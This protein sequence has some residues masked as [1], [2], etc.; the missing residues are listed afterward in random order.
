MNWVGISNENEFYSE[1]YLSEVFS[2]DIKSLLD[3]WL[4]QEKS[5]KAEATGGKVAEYTRTP[6]NRLGSLNSEWLLLAREL[7]KA[8]NVEDRLELQRSWLQ[9]LCAC[10]ELPWNAENRALDDNCSIPL[11]AELLDADGKPVLWV[12]EA[13]ADNAID[14]D[15]L[16]L[17]VLPAQL[18]NAEVPLPK[19]MVDKNWQTLL[20]TDVYT[21]D[22][23][24]RWIILASAQQW[25]LLDR[26][27]FAQNRLLRFDWA[28][29][30]SRR[31]TDTLKATA[32]L[33]HKD[34]L[35]SKTG[36]TSGSLHDDIDESA[37]KHAYGVSEDLKYALRECIE[38]L[39]NE[40]ALQLVARARH[41]KEG[42]YSGTNELPADKLTNECLRYMYRLLFLFYIEA[43]SELSYAPVD[44]QTYMAS[45][46]LEHLR[47]LELIELN[48]E[49]DRS[50]RYIHDTI[51]TLFELIDNGFE[52]PVQQTLGTT[53][54]A[55]RIAP[56]KSHLFQPQRMKLLEKVVFPN[57]ILQRVIELMSRRI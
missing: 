1:H 46:S 50:G 31:E 54:S 37:H 27:K 56:L 45:Y 11:L 10:L 25:L 26:S 4:E 23:V 41:Q 55:F 8:R 9:E 14:A 19:A 22:D 12:V 49:A 40:A 15:P 7:Q 18:G 13:L 30:I 20:T 16:T 44:S 33:L 43:R 34:S 52:P 38:L 3:A 35:L 6:Y 29:I 24:P 32:V 36:T 48:T 47:N 42:I 17:K 53:A 21:S 39:G 28:E 5:A 51:S 57:H 2:G